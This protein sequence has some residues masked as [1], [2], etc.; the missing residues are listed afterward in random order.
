MYSAGG[1]IAAVGGVAAMAAGSSMINRH[2][3]TTQKAGMAAAAGGAALMGA[4]IAEAIDVKKERQ[5]FINLYNAFIRNY[6]G[7]PD[8]DM[9][10]RT[11]PPPLPD[12]PVDIPPVDDSPLSGKDPKP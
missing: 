10:L 8:P 6:Y 2:S 7:S 5:K 11:P 4:A 3:P 12:V 9:E 1:T